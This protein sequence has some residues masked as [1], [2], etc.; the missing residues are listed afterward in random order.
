[1]CHGEHVEV[2]GQYGHSFST[3]KHGTPQEQT[4]PILRLAE[5]AFTT[6]SILSTPPWVFDSSLIICVLC[7]LIHHHYSKDCD[8]RFIYK[9]FYIFPIIL[10]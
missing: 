2:K 5:K 1:M 10:V 7:F 9:P 4:P 8:G 3:F 6:Q